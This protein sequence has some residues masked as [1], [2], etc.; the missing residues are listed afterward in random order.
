MRRSDWGE[1]VQAAQRAGR[2]N[3]AT[4]KGRNPQEQHSTGHRLGFRRLRAFLPFCLSLV[5]TQRLL[6]VS[7][8]S[9]SLYDSHILSS[10][11]KPDV[12]RRDTVSAIIC[13]WACTVG[14]PGDGFDLNYPSHRRVPCT[15]P[16]NAETATGRF[17][18]SLHSTLRDTGSYVAKPLLHA[19]PWP[20][21]ATAYTSA[22]ENKRE[23]AVNAMEEKE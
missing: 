11:V 16:R 14:E 2:D 4:S 10:L 21:F 23:A 19:L 7:W 8:V 12:P 20:L 17:A 18:G 1:G 13:C 5:I 15:I 22:R 3:A 9:H 6:T